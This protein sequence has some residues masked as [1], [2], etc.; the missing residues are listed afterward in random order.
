MATEQ[1]STIE[2]HAGGFRE[3]DDYQLLCSQFTYTQFLH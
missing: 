1:R 2:T 3:L